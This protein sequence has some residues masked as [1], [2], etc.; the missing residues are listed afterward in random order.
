MPTEVKISKE[1]I[2]SDLEI[3]KVESPMKELSAVKSSEEIL[4]LAVAAAH[5]LNKD[6]SDINVDGANQEAVSLWTEAL[7][8][9]DYEGIKS[10]I[11]N[12]LSITDSTE[13]GN[14]LKILPDLIRLFEGDVKPLRILNMNSCRGNI[15]AKAAQD[16]P[17]ARIVSEDLNP[18]HCMLQQIVSRVFNLPIEVRIDRLNHKTEKGRFDL[19]LG[20]LPFGMRRVERTPIL[21]FNGEEIN[22]RS[23]EAELVNDALISLDKDGIAALVTTPSVLFSN[24]EKK[25][26]NAL[27]KSSVIEKVIQLPAGILPNTSISPVLLIL[28]KKENSKIQICDLNSIF[29]LG[30]KKSLQKQK[31]LLEGLESTIRNHETL[32]N[33][34]SVAEAEA[35]SSLLYPQRYYTQT[36]LRDFENTYCVKDVAEVF[37]GKN[38]AKMNENAEGDCYLLTAK[39]L[40]DQQIDISALETIGEDSSA[41]ND[42][43]LMDGDILIFSKGV[44]PQIAF[45]EGIGEMHVIPSSNFLVIR[46]DLQKIDPRYLMAYLTSSDG[47]NRLESISKGSVIKN[48]TTPDLKNMEIP[49]LDLEQQK[50]MGAR[51]KILQDRLKEAR[52]R[53]ERIIAKRDSLFDEGGESLGV[54]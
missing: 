15:T 53:V 29:S 32:F 48:I 1:R 54:R 12:A 14:G 3:L 49:K 43:Y 45:M 23:Y 13:P 25:F 22:V 20:E 24:S 37:R 26:V 35:D 36:S 7:R 17:T 18:R 44:A 52:Q 33:D 31:E 11:I 40:R 34:L 4:N 41:Q 46:P 9:L 21:A 38:L 39:A 10:T 28:S 47:K 30:R 27:I 2:A 51:Y 6:I 50:V 42:I 16:F 19:V 8:D 5:V